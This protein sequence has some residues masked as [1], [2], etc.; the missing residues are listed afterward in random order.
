MYRT[1]VVVVAWIVLFAALPGQVAA[2]TAG[3]SA[4]E[5]WQWEDCRAPWNPAA[6]ADEKFGVNESFRATEIAKNLGA[7]WSRFVF[8]W[9]QVEEEEGNYQKLTH[10][11]YLGPGTLDRELNHGFKIYGLLKN[12]PPFAQLDPASGVRSKPDLEKWGQFVRVIV[13]H[14]KGKI[15]HWAIWNEVEISPGGAN[16]TY[17]TFVGTAADYKALLKV[18][19][20]V[21][22]SVNPDAKIILAPYSYHHDLHEGGEQSLPWFE[23]L[24]DALVADP[25]AAANN[26]Y[27]DIFAMNIYRNPHD[28]Y[29]RIAGSIP[30]SVR[31]PDRSSIK[32]KLESRGIDPNRFEWWIT[33]M[34]FMAY[35][36]FEAAGWDANAKNDGFRITMQEQAAALVQAYAL[37]L[38]AGWDKVFWH[39][40][41]DDPPPPPDELWGLA[42]FNGHLRNTDTGRLRPAACAYLMA[43]RYMSHASN[44]RLHTLDRP[45]QTIDPNGT[46]NPNPRQYAPRFE[47]HVQQATFDRGSERS[48]VLWNS[49]PDDV[50]I[51]VQRS[52]ETARLF[53]MFGNE[54]TLLQ[55]GNS[56]LVDLG[57]ATRHFS[58]FGG[59]PASYFFIGGPPVFL[60]EYNPTNTEPIAPR[61][62]TAAEIDANVKAP[63]PEVSVPTQG[64]DFA[65][66]NGHFYP[67][68]RGDRPI[69][70][71]Y[72]IVN[73]ELCPCY[74]QFIALGGVGELGYPASQ[75]Y[76]EGPFIYQATQGVLLQWNP[77]SGVMNIANVFD[78]LSANGFDDYLEVKKQIP[79]S[80]DWSSDDGRPFHGAGSIVENHFSVIFDAR[81]ED[82][83]AM[84]AARPVLR[85]TYEANPNWL[86]HYGLPMGIKEYGNVIVVRGQRAAFQ[87]WK[88]DVPWAAQGQVTKV[89]GGDVYKDSGLIPDEAVVPIAAPDS[90]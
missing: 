83:E 58:L 50:T 69:N 17:N 73:D 48:F 74:T 27:F 79:P 16:A 77:E 88:E 46:F 39:A 41:S 40:M 26:Y 43:A 85:A 29:D 2:T 61:L 81:S 56:W 28:L 1:A 35:D 25:E 4:A 54:L 23:S 7:K 12:T 78:I 64:D 45:N 5:S 60:I 87:Y 6:F 31:P 68:A 18:A 75:P 66:A 22:K 82:S 53:D 42:R 62:A 10:Q 72:T 65:I 76:Q 63:A 33:E 9:S 71:G 90:P 14:Y 57:R 38:S 55:S 89:L 49:G 70:F 84:R 11:F 47:W 36:D 30:W 51:A 32:S 52:A 24:V 3:Q 44:I 20:E 80:F 59:D 37:A 21:A 8:E 15:D 34:N 19:Y 13:G 86:L 67:Q